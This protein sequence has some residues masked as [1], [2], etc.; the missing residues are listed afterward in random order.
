M[1]KPKIRD[2]VYV[3]C[4]ED[5]TLFFFTTTSKTKGYRLNR[6]SQNLLTLINC[7]RSVEEIL[8]MMRVE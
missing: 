2:S 1:R 7:E 3:C 5:E 8:V 6:L 4:R